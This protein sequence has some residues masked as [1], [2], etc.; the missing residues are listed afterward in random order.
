MAKQS[1]DVLPEYARLLLAIRKQ[2]GWT[3][4]QL[5]QALCVSVRTIQYWESGARSPN[6]RD[7]H[8][9]RQMLT[10]NTHNVRP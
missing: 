4:Q 9:L 8:T 10:E 7:M 3:Q 1:L 5:A 2:R 6:V